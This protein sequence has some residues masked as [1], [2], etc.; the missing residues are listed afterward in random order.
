VAAAKEWVQ[1][2]FGGEAFLG[3]H[4][5]SKDFGALRICFQDE[6]VNA[7]L[8][9]EKVARCAAAV[10]RREGF[11]RVV[12]CSDGTAAKVRILHSYLTL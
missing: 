7:C 10:V 5:R 6:Y 1:R 11:K 9:P 12:L 8:A 2:Q 3:I 4:W